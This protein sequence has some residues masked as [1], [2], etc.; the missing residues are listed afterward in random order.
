[1]NY[2]PSIGQA[3]VSN[4]GTSTTS[5]L[6]KALEDAWRRQHGLYYHEKAMPIPARHSAD[7][8]HVF[9]PKKCMQLGLCICNQ[10][11]K[12][13]HLFW[14][15]LSDALKPKVAK[16]T[17]G[18]SEL[19][20]ALVV[21]KFQCGGIN[22]ATTTKFF[23]IGY[24]NLKTW[25]FCMLEMVSRCEARRGI[26]PLRLA[27]QQDGLESP[28]AG[29]GIAVQVFAKYFDL[30]LIW[31]CKY[32]II[33]QPA[34]SFLNL[35]DMLPH[36]I[37]ILDDPE[38]QPFFFWNG[39]DG[40]KPTRKRQIVPTD[41]RNVKKPRSG[42][43][44]GPGQL[45]E[46]QPR[47]PAVEDDL[48]DAVAAEEMD[49]RSEKSYSPSI[50]PASSDADE[51]DE[52]LSEDDGLKNPQLLIAEQWLDLAEAEFMYDM[53]EEPATTVARNLDDLLD[54][55]AE[56]GASKDADATHGDNSI[57]VDAVTSTAAIPC[58][59]ASSVNTDSISITESSDHLDLSAESSRDAR[60]DDC[61]GS[62][63]GGDERDVEVE[64]SHVAGPSAPPGL[65]STALRADDRLDYPPHGSIRYNFRSESL[66]AHCSYHSGNCR[67]TRIAKPAANPS[68][69]PGQGRPVGLLSAWLEEGSRFDSAQ[70]HSQSCHPNLQLRREARHR[71][72]SLPGASDFCRSY[73]RP[74]RDSENEEPENLN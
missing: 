22:H 30:D 57:G 9:V 8:R 32:C 21:L 3:V 52:H 11:G 17:L 24:I 62:A 70:L 19:N 43:A 36:H 44:A 6:M 26:Q 13:A 2:R 4:P 18:R 33:Q 1:M 69:N 49:K 29:I 56:T 63:S 60:S 67:R 31:T 15:K 65:K 12:A 46:E 41:K 39:Y 23:H 72:S 58:D 73:E 35:S 59:D 68:R 38:E 20:A 10:P 7:A 51:N 42:P 54:A 64:D 55:A 66:V 14:T 37:D 48:Q 53:P 50:R 71:F 45:G 74:R 27:G 5:G 28:I 25:H 16:K 47:V 34:T 61:A 40:E